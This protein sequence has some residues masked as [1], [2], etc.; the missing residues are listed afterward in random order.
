MGKNTNQIA[1]YT[2]YYYRG[3]AYNGASNKCM[4]Y[5]SLY[6]QSDIYKGHARGNWSGASLI[7]SAVDADGNW[8]VDKYKCVKFS[9]YSTTPVRVPWVLTISENVTG[10]TRARTIEVRY[11]YKTSSSAA[12]TY[13]VMGSYT[14]S[15]NISGSASQ[16][17]FL[18]ANPYALYNGSVYS[19]RVVFWCGTTNNK[20]DWEYKMKKRSASGGS[21]GTWQSSYTEAG[22]NKKTCEVCP[23]GTQSQELGM[24]QTLLDYNGIEFHIKN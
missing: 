15:S 9:Q 4:T 24:I 1:T 16:T 23:S 3:H 17:Q 6:I 10:A 8:S 22:Y 20:Q 14:F 2:D 13:K 5:N 11:Y 19:S 12:E 21:S 7:S 18:E